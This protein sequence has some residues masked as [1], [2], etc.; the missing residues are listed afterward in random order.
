MSA[1]TGKERDALTRSKSIRVGFRQ[2]EVQRLRCCTSNGGV[3]GSIPH[4]GT[5]MPRAACFFL[6]VEEWIPNLFDVLCSDKPQ[7]C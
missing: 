2:L 7:N 3:E 1:L 4:Q 5:K 6:T